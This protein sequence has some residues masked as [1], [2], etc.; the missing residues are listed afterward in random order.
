[1]TNL[2]VVK[3]ATVQALYCWLSLNGPLYRWVALLSGLG[4]AALIGA[5]GAA[6]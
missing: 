5:K 4:S 1:M 6:D 3:Q 2:G